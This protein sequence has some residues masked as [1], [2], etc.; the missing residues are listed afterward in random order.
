MTLRDSANLAERFAKPSRRMFLSVTALSAAGFLIGCDSKPT[1]P[2][3]TG[4][5]E[6]FDAA[7]NWFVRVG[8][9]NTVT[10]LNKHIE[11]G[12]GTA[13][14]LSTLVAEEMDADWSQIRVE[15]APADASKYGNT[16]LGGAQGTG[17]STAMADSYQKMRVA[18]AGARAMLIAAAAK[19]FGVDAGT[20]AIEKGVVRTADGSKK[21]T[22]GELAADAAKIAPPAV[23]TLKFKDAANYT[24]VGKS[25]A[26]LDSPGKTDG[27]AVFGYDYR[28]KD[29]VTALIARPPKFGGTVKSFDDSAAKKLPGTVAVV[30]VPQGVAVLAKDMW[31][32]IKAREALKVE[33]DFA[34]AETRG[35]AEMMA[36][37]KKLASGAGVSARKEGDAAAAMK[38]AKKKLSAD[39][40]FPFLAHAPLEALNCTVVLTADS[41][42]MWFGS[43]FPSLDQPTAAAIAGLKPEQ[44]KIHTL[45]A[46][47]SFGRRATPTA[48]LAA[49]AVGVAKAWGGKAPVK[50]VHTREDDIKGGYYRPMVLHRMAA[51]LDAQG[52]PV[53]W[54]NRIVTQ[55]IMEGT[56]FL[57]AGQIDFTAIEG[58]ADLPYVFANMDVDVHLPKSAVPVLWWRSVGHTHTAFATEVFLDEVAKAAGKDPL[59]FRRTLLAKHPRHLGVLNLAAEKA[60]WG[61][62][63]E[64]GRARGI[65]VHESF[66]SFVAHVAEI[67]VKPD[68]SFTVD[69]VVCAVDCGIAVNPDVIVAQMEGGIG[70]GLS[71]ALHEAITLTKG[72]VDQSNFT[73][74]TILRASEMPKVEV[75]IVPSTEKPTG[76]GE[77]GLPPIAPAV[78]NAIF[79]ATGKSVRKL[80]M[81]TKVP[82]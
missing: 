47:G 44:V 65:A 36:D 37:Y 56:P 19:R 52:V 72:E 13:T 79:A 32:A 43:Q 33:W 5:A 30:Q 16:I 48:D 58:S 59:E 67:T 62:P 45:Y 53:A 70:Y 50:L 21:A 25:F 4:P 17:G 82:A 29:A 10:V 39:F 38:G 12:Q 8:S 42:E 27:S 80:P 54:T 22:F 63:M 57:P 73:D 34:K 11:F 1:T 66:S 77:P 64:K 40:E 35:S 31:A 7:M 61:T 75:H 46:G 78:A 49:E 14:G 9:D 41:C 81:G 60:G 2:A 18:G 76:V 68:R 3:A 26:R 71:A 55:S 15:H 20:L 28:P 74:Y 24:Y 23:E 69:R 51:G 6:A